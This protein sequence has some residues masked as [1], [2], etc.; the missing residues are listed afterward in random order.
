MGLA[1]QIHFSASHS[2]AGSQSSSSGSVLLGPMSLQDPTTF[3]AKLLYILF[4]LRV[5]DN[6][7]R[8]ISSSKLS[9]NLNSFHEIS[10]D[11]LTI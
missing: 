11:Y 6:L 7:G 10:E 1:K 8:G 4:I 3:A 2:E 9:E 5:T